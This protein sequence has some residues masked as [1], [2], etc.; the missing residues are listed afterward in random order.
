MRQNNRVTASVVIPAFTFD[1]WDNI[2]KAVDAV[3]AQT[4]LPVELI[5]CIDR[6]PELLAACQRRWGSAALPVPV[7]VMANANE[8]VPRVATEAS[9]DGVARGYGGGSARNA[10]AAAATGDVIVTFDDDA[11]PEPDCL[12]YLLAPYDDPAVVAVGGKT[13][14]DFETARPRWFPRTFDWI[15]GCAYDGLPTVLAPT[16]RLIG[17]NM[18]VRA[19]AFR[20]LG[21]FRAVDFD[22]LDMC[23]RLA[24]RFRD[25]AL[26]Y[27]PRAVA[28][29]F[30]P[31]KR[32]TWRYFWTRN[33][34]VNRDKVPAFAQM[35]EAA[36]LAAE[37]SFV[38]RAIRGHAAAAARGVFTGKPEEVL[39]LGAALIGIALAGIGNAVGRLQMWW[40]RRKPA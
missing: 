27:E 38:L 5:L 2:A 25:S 12:S 18:S 28:H 3:A 17:A 13:V 24:Y 21:G 16:P 9:S 40:E 14:P 4:R 11:W 39:Q 35:G 20:E 7:K 32:V 19:S 30:V 26:L 33:F 1:R 8:W 6:N 34:L 10:G 29:H 22:D 36:S 15:F 31:A 37:F 23:T